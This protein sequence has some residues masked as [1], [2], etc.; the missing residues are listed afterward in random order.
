MKRTIDLTKEE[1]PERTDIKNLRQTLEQDGYANIP[2]MTRDEAEIFA[3]E[4]WTWLGGFGTGITREDTSTHASDNWPPNIHGLIQ[5][6]GAGQTLFA[7]KIRCLKVLRE[8][9]AELW[10]VPEQELVVSFDGINVG[11]PYPHDQTWYHLDQSK[12]GSNFKAWQA[13]LSL[14]DSNGGLLFYEGSHK[15]H[16]QFLESQ[17]AK[18][19]AVGWYQLNDSDR[20]WYLKQSEVRSAF[21]PSQAGYLTMWDSRVVHSG[22]RPVS[23]E[24]RLCVYVC[25]APFK[26]GI[27][28]KNVQKELAKKC[29]YF[30]ER[31]MTKHT[32][33][34]ARLF[35]ETFQHHGK[36][37]LVEKFKKQPTIADSEVTVDML[38]LI[39]YSHLNAEGQMH[40]INFRKRAA[41]AKRLKEKKQ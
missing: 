6:F 19:L 3:S 22:K 32:P 30:E 11:K 33:L 36:A 18:P 9:F 35:S 31:R 37:Y 34:P 26:F 4:I 20:V 29:F 14:T 41:V 7:W 8:I 23:G 12:E 15:V 17:A 38:S 40:L 25:Y 39:G 10:R 5:R 2:V 16:A 1:R 13:A 27:A 28:P 21:V 24:P